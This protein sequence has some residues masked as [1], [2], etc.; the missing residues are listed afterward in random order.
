MQYTGESV[1]L[2]NVKINNDLW[3]CLWLVVINVASV[4]TKAFQI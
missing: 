4:K 2:A 3:D 1:A